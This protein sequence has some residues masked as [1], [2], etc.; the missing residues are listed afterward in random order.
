MPDCSLWQQCQFCL[1]FASM[2]NMTILSFQIT[3]SPHS[4]PTFPGTCK[5]KF[6][7][8]Q[9]ISFEFLRVDSIGWIVSRGKHFVHMTRPGARDWPAA[10]F[11]RPISHT[12]TFTI[13]PHSAPTFPG[14]C[15]R[16][17]LCLQMI[18]FE[19]LR[20]DSIGWIVS[21]G[22]HF[23]HMTRPGAR[24]WPAACFPRPISH[25][26]TFTTIQQVNK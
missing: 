19:F 14:T 1:P 17:F 5:R 9:M 7:C 8:L 2:L 6:L 20:V 15:K 21:R 12:I 10:C 4:A 18:S 25:T 24:D 13:S 23:V 11:P 26:I 22:K 16:K 3:I